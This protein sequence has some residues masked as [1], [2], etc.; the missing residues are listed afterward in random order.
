MNNPVVNIHVKLLC[1][2][3][4]NLSSVCISVVELLG[5]TGTPCLAF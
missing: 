2:R 1:G 4:P 3:F 5:H